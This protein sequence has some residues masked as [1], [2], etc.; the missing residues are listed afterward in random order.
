MYQAS[1]MKKIV[2]LS[3]YAILLAS[4]LNLAVPVLAHDAGNPYEADLIAGQYINVGNVLVWNDGTNLYVKYVTDY[5][6]LTETHLYVSTEEPEKAAPGKF[7]YKMEYASPVMEYTYTIPLN[8]WTA[9]TQLWIAAHA[10]VLNP[11]TCKDETAWAWGPCHHRELPGKSWGWYFWY[12][13]Q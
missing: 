12:I 13:V 5:W 1:S 9:G 7:D 8:G 11:S 4:L 6:K 10:V 3:A 2:K